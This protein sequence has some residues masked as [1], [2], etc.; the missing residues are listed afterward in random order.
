MLILQLCTLSSYLL[1]LWEW[2]CTVMFKT[3][4]H[5]YDCEYWKMTKIFLKSS[6]GIPS[7]EFDPCYY[8]FIFYFLLVPLFCRFMGHSRTMWPNHIDCKYNSVLEWHRIKDMIIFFFSTPFHH[9]SN[10]CSSNAVVTIN[11]GIKWVQ[12]W[13]WFRF[14]FLIFCHNN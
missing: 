3:K 1:L 4:F 5:P 2:D 6:N 10:N 7:I 9:S 13:Y 14:I 8:I 11:D 12:D